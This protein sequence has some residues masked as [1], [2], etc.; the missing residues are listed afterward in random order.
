MMSCSDSKM[1]QNGA[2]P[3]YLR[4]VSSWS[5]RLNT[6][7]GD[8]GALAQ[9]RV[10]ATAL[11]ERVLRADHVEDVIHDLK[12]HAQLAGERAQKIDCYRSAGTDEK[13]DALYA[14][15]DQPSGLELM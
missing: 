9:P 4:I 8:V 12:Q 1:E 11:A 2:S 7:L 6:E 14:G 13:Q 5:R 3:P 15:R 10:T